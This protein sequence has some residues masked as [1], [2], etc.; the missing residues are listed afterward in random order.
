MIDEEPEHDNGYVALVNVSE[1]NGQ[2]IECEERTEI[3]AWKH[4]H[5]S[6]G[7]VTYTKLTGDVRLFNVDFEYEPENPVLHDVSLYAKPGQKVAFV[8]ATGW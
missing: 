7:S 8:G 3:W 6:D 5:S 4:P 1:E 2:L